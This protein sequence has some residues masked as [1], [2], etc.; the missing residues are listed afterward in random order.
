MNTWKIILATMFI[1]G[2]GV[3]TGGLLVRHS[4]G[5][6]ARP[7]TRSAARAAQPAS[8]GGM[9]FEFMR[10]ME[11]ELALSPE[12]REQIDKI[13]KESQDRTRKVMAPYLREEL[14]RTTA[15]F[16][17]ALTPEQR[18]R[19]DELLKQKQQQRAREQHR[20]A[21]EPERFLP[22]SALTNK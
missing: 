21:A 17:E 7:Q 4:D 11:K 5:I 3:V 1:F 22:G 6:R 14:Q 12:Q 10:R 20:P 2:T 18:Q 15:D 19:F 9:R 16:R 13:L 8:P